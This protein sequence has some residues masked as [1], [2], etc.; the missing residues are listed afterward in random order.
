MPLT[1]E[2]IGSQFFTDLQ[3]RVPQPPPEELNFTAPYTVVEVEDAGETVALPLAGGWQP[4]SPSRAASAIISARR[5][6]MR[7]LSAFIAGAEERVE[8]APAEPDSG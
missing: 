6:P 7:L 4:A 2:Q 1:M 3:E 8:T 5:S